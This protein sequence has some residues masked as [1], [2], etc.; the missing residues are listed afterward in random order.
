MARPARVWA[1]RGSGIRGERSSRPHRCRTQRSS[2][3]PPVVS[4]SALLP[5]WI[6]PRRRPGIQHSGVRFGCGQDTRRRGRRRRPRRRGRCHC[7]R[8]RGR[9][10]GRVARRRGGHR[11]RPRHR[12]YWRQRR[13][14]G[15]RLRGR[16]RRRPRH[17]R[18]L[19]QRRGPG[20][21]RPSGRHRRRPRHR[22]SGCRRWRR[23]G[24]W[25][26]GCGR[27]RPYIRHR[28]R[29][30]DGRHRQGPHD[31][32]CRWR[33]RSAPRNQQ[34]GFGL[35]VGDKVV[36]VDLVGIFAKQVVH[37]RA[38]HACIGRDRRGVGEGRR[39]PGEPLRELCRAA[40]KLERPVVVFHVAR[41]L[42]GPPQPYN[43]VH[44]LIALPERVGG[45]QR[46]DHVLGVGI[47]RRRDSKHCRAYSYHPE[48]V[49]AALT[50][51]REAREPSRHRTR[52]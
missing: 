27:S 34:Q 51:P 18:C 36:D 38:R 52:R 13:G 22:R 17:R 48:G 2:R 26:R 43:R 6:A 20:G 33:P 5:R 37:G 8:P 45:L 50:W 9:H 15:G 30:R 11:R 21:R 42:R 24:R 31:R 25:P 1:R 39:I 32:R 46:P 41:G 12:W 44:P 35:R 23:R 3:L 40:G 28:Q 47:D 29:L 7:R 16:C 4:R 49:F 14:L 10:G 19:R